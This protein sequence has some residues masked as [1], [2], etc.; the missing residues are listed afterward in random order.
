M[1]RTAKQRIRLMLKR[2]GVSPAKGFCCVRISQIM[3]AKLPKTKKLRDFHLFFLQIFFKRH[4]LA[5]K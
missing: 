3:I 5:L 1:M 4:I 2:K